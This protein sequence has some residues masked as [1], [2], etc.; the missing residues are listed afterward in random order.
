MICGGKTQS[1]RKNQPGMNNG[2]KI[3][4]EPLIEKKN[5]A[6]K[7]CNNDY[8]T[9]ETRPSYCTSRMDQINAT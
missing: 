5:C 1:H 6:T 7:V 8:I 2:L 3:Q 9:G 4:V